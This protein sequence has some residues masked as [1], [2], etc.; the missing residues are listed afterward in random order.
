MFLYPEKNLFLVVNMK[1]LRMCEEKGC[2]RAARYEWH[3]K[4]MCTYHFRNM[5]DTMEY[6]EDQ[7]HFQ[8]GLGYI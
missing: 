1:K 5:V 6:I 3:G 8:V 4:M 2:K 7:R